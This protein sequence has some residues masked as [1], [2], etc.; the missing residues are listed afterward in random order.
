[1]STVQCGWDCSSV[2]DC[3]DCVSISGIA[4][5]HFDVDHLESFWLVFAMPEF[6]LRCP[7]YVSFRSFATIFTSILVRFAAIFIVGSIVRLALE[8][9]WHLRRQFD[10]QSFVAVVRTHTRA[11]SSWLWHMTFVYEWYQLKQQTDSHCLHAWIWVS[12]GHSV[13]FQMSSCL[14]GSHISRSPFENWE[15]VINRYKFMLVIVAYATTLKRS[16]IVLLAE[17]HCQWFHKLQLHAI[18]SCIEYAIW[19]VH[20]V[21]QQSYSFHPTRPSTTHQ[22]IEKCIFEFENVIRLTMQLRCQQCD[23]DSTASSWQYV[24]DDDLCETICSNI[25]TQT[26]NLLLKLLLMLRSRPKSILN[27][28]NINSGHWRC[29]R[30]ISH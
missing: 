7:F 26:L 3:F 16:L 28:Q 8:C 10:S 22:R 29:C 20:C 25:H 13:R 12:V 19:N 2:F 4:L 27:K 23:T 18:E 30:I 11:Q 1:M 9:V 14:F 24:S 5:W 6:H 21:G 15:I 17:R